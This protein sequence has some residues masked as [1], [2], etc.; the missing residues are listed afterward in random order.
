MQELNPKNGKE[1]CH[2]ASQWAFD[3][4]ADLGYDV[5]FATVHGSYLYGTAHSES[6]VD[7]YV[8]VQEGKSSQ[9]V[10]PDRT[11]VLLVSLDKF[12]ELVAGGSHQAVEAP[13][14]PYKVVGRDNPFSYLMGA[15]RPPRNEFMRKCLS[16]ARS[17][18]GRVAEGGERNPEK[19]LLHAQR[20]EDSALAMLEGRYNPVYKELSP[21]IDYPQLPGKQKRGEL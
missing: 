8:V 15:L 21:E 12:L 3:H 11:D 13:Y 10:F 20:L 2:R 7:F 4:Y 16:A 5:I 19:L 18:R 14:S 1:F 17:F 9:K 6:D